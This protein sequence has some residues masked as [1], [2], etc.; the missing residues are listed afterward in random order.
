MIYDHKSINHYFVNLEAIFRWYRSWNLR[1]V[2]YGNQRQILFLI[3][4]IKE[5]VNAE[6]KKYSKLKW[7][8]D[9]NKVIEARI[10]FTAE[11]CK[12]CKAMTKFLEKT[13]MNGNSYYTDIQT[14]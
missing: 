8:K 12:S 1:N 9:D 10:N 3:T 6:Y 11:L 2:R 13:N 14:M 7:N 5:L 4:G